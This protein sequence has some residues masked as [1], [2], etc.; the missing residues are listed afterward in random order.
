MLYNQAQLARVYAQAYELTGEQRYADVTRWTLEYVLRD[1]RDAEHGFYSATDAD[2]AA[3]IG[4]EAEEGLFFLWTIEELQAV[5]PEKLATLAIQLFDV[6][7]EGN[8]EGENI[9]YLPQNYA[10]FAQAHNLSTAELLADLAK[11]RQILYEV[12]EKRPQ[13]LLDNKVITAWNGMMITSFAEAGRILDNRGYIA[14]A[15]QAANFIWHHQRD[16]NNHLWRVSLEGETSIVGQLE[17]YAYTIEAFLSLYDADGLAI[18][19]ERAEILAEV[20]IAQFWD[21]EQSGFFMTSG[22]DSTLLIRPKNAED[23]AIASSNGVALVALNR[24]GQRT[25]KLEYIEKAQQTLAAFADEV[26][27]YPSAYATLL[28]GAQAQWAGQAGA[29]RYAAAGAVKIVFKQ[30]QQGIELDFN[31]KAGWH[32]NAANIEDTDLI[33]TALKVDDEAWALTHIQYPSAKQQAVQFRDKPLD[34]YAGQFAISAM[35]EAKN[36]TDKAY[37]PINLRLQACNETT[38]LAPETILFYAQRSS[39]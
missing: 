9:L 21:A 36:A 1:M 31:L 10:K 3:K 27:A 33:A 8:F 22:D 20:M 19:L 15:Q 12:R 24:L 16:K 23:G 6:T 39:K 17:D 13:P 35:L 29:V 5:L 25:G 37:I 4:E 2:S 14:A 11:I 30:T 28:R 34:L 38:C 7:P 18:W 26:A 32:V